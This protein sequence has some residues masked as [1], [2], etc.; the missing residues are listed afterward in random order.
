MFVTGPVKGKGVYKKKGRRPE[1]F[2]QG[3]IIICMGAGE[4]GEAETNG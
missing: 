1:R 4:K 3:V 2:R